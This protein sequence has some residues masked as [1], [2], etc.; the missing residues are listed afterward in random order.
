[1][2]KINYNI[3]KVLGLMA[4]FIV[5]SIPAYAQNN[6][7]APSDQDQSSTFQNQFTG[8]DAQQFA[9]NLAQQL[10]LTS[11]IADKI[12]QILVDYRNSILE[13]RQDYL[14][15]NPGMTNNDRKNTGNQ[16][17]TGGQ[18]RGITS[19]NIDSDP[20]LL[21][22]YSKA[23]VQADKDIIDAMDNDTQ[24]AK[25]IQIKKQWW[26]GVKDRVYSSVKQGS[27]QQTE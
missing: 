23:D 1:M 7:A 15:K 27:G 12:T 16:D 22:E 11:G 2:S 14:N 21:S 10:N 26:K 18:K 8:N 3:L 13:A 24:K 25:Y 17:V 20:N 5:I 19:S 9:N 6:T 4:M